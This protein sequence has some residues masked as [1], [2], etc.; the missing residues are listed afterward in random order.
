M[1]LMKGKIKNLFSFI[2]RAWTGGIY[3]K[4]G[5]V[6]FLFAFFLFVRVFWGDV[7]VQ[8]FAMNI[9][10]L[11]NAQEQ[12]VAEQ[13]TLD[14]LNRHIKLLQNYSPDYVEELGLR[15]LNIG[16]PRVKILKI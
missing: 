3:G 4:F 8:R 16:D 14:E 10:H 12:L 11:R 2:G 5:I 6:L 15:Y 7:N 13:A 9:F 1:T